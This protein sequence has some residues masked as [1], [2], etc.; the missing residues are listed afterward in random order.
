MKATRSALNYYFAIGRVLSCLTTLAVVLSLAL[1]ATWAYKRPAGGIHDDDDDHRPATAIG[2]VFYDPPQ[3]PQSQ[4]PGI[5][6]RQ[7]G[8]KFSLTQ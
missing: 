7:K 6:V 2:T 3:P 5:Y 1:R 8:S 4:H